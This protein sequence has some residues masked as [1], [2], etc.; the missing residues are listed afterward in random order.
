MAGLQAY[1]EKFDS[2]GWDCYM[3]GDPQLS[4]LTGCWDARYEFKHWSNVVCFK[5]DETPL[6]DTIVNDHTPFLPK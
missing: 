1:V 6:A 3:D 4:R 5:R 2:F